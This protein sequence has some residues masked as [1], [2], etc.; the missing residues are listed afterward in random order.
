MAATA[1]AAATSKRGT[2]TSAVAAAAAAAAAA[3]P[4]PQQHVHLV[5]DYAEHDLLQVLECHRN[6]A[7]KPPAGSAPSPGVQSTGIPL[8]PQMIKSILWQILNG[9]AYLHS[10]WVLH[11]D[12]K[13]ANILIM[14][15]GRE[16]GTVK[17]ADLGLARVFRSPLHSLVQA[18]RVVVTIWYRAPELLLGAK[19]YTKAV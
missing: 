7:A 18:D 5:L 2:S 8:P 10:Q 11:R 6:A 17:I 14:G 12:L 13:P 4:R 3:A 1:A 15:E 9:V 19:H 16:I